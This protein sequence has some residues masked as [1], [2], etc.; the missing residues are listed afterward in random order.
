MNE[1]SIISQRIAEVISLGV[2]SD[3]AITS[4]EYIPKEFFNDM[5]SSWK[6][7]VKRIHAEEEFANVDRAAEALSI[8]VGF[9][10]S[11]YI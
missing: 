10:Q 3:Q 9:E 2:E 8:A 6:G 4:L 1:C 11:L 7:R 5:E